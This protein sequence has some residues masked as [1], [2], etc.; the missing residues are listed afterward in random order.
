LLS[1]F[2]SLV[3]TVCKLGCFIVT[4][5]YREYALLRQ[6]E[7]WSPALAHRRRCTSQIPHQCSYNGDGTPQTIFLQ[8]AQFRMCLRMP[9]SLHVGPGRLLTDDLLSGEATRMEVLTGVVH[10]RYDLLRQCLGHNDCA[11]QYLGRAKL[12]SVEECTLMQAHAIR[13]LQ[14]ILRTALSR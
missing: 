4:S 1:A 10:G 5:V 7:Y 13:T 2:Q 11:D 14:A 12:L 3:S 6:P 9:V 8:S